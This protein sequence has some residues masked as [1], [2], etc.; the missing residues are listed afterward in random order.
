MKSS[1]L[2]EV[3]AGYTFFWSGRPKAERRDTGV[4]FAIG[5]D[6][7]GRLICLPQGFNDRLM[8]HRLPLREDNFANI[9]SVYVPIMAS[10]D[11]AK[12]E[13]CE[14]LH[15]LLV[16]LPKADK[17]ILLE[18]LQAKDENATVETRC[19]RLRNVIHSIA[20]EVLRR[21]CRQHQDWFDENDAKISNLLAEKNRFNKAYMDFR[22]DATKATFFRCRR[23]VHQRPREMQDAW[24]VCKAK[25]NQAYERNEMKIFFKAV[26]AIY[27]PCIK[28]TARCSV[29]M[30]QHF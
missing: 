11:A 2:E 5:N 20:L 23:L 15:A 8:S 22:T 12:D 29:L 24:M 28:G 21:A 7:V 4:T 25:E 10:S 13:F 6:I 26:K 27:G 9:I 3:G 18:N 19:C 1:Q 30:A 14:D 16:T 17:L